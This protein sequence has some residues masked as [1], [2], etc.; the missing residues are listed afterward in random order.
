MKILFLCHRFPLPAEGGAKIRALHMIRHLSRGAHEVTVVSLIRSD[1]E[2]RS[3]Q[4][5]ERS[6][7]RCVV[8]RV[9][10]LSQIARMVG[11]L[12]GS[13]PSSFG[14]FFS[15]QLARRVNSILRDEQWDLV[16]AYSSSMGPYVSAFDAAPKIL[17]F[18]DMDSQKWL[19]YAGH[20]RFPMNLGYLLEGRKL[21]RAERRLARRFD[22]CT[23]ISANEHETLK[24]LTSG[25]TADWFPNGVDLEYFSPSTGDYDPNLIV[26]VGRMD[27]FPNQQAMQW[28]CTRVWPEL[29]AARRQLI[30]RIVGA[31]PNAA[32]RAL[33]AYDGVEVTGSVPDVRPYVQGAAVSIA[34]L[35]IA[36]G[37]QNKV[38]ESMAMAIPVVAT[39][40]VGAGLGVGAGAPLFLADTPDEFRRLILELVDSR[41]RRMKVAAESRLLVETEFS[42]PRA[43]QRFDAIVAEC[44]LQAAIN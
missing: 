28:F 27:Y 4:D 26:F 16:I 35:Q 20:K 5:L 39:R 40:R 10:T 42:W 43:M 22:Y 6:G 38:L 34:P 33:A 24:S 2:L 18:V 30:L 12:F 32:V 17:D 37:M 31:K 7:I 8:E 44:L 13:E 19:D 9:G 23:T 36:R 25:M 41:E 11:R 29:H 1:V 15:R 3:V 21:E 14:Y